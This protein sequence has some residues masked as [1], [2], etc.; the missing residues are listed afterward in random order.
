M[1]KLSYFHFGLH[2]LPQGKKLNFPPF[3]M[4]L[5]TCKALTLQLPPETHNHALPQLVVYPVLKSSCTT[6]Q[7]L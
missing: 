6:A 5:L 7:R 2:W 3:N 1:P 4:N